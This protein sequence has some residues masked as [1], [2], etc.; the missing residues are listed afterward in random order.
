MAK[1]AAAPLSLVLVGTIAAVF[2]LSL[3]QNN[4]AF[5]HDSTPNI[6]EN[7]LVVTAA[8]SSVTRSGTVTITAT[9]FA[10]RTG[11]GTDTDWSLQLTV[12]AGYTISSGANPQAKSTS[13]HSSAV[14]NW[15][16]TAPA[17]PSGPDTFTVTA[18]A[19]DAS[20]GTP[21]S[22]SP[23]AD[24]FTITTINRNPAAADDGVTIAEDAPSAIF[25][26]LNDTDADNDALFISSVSSQPANGTAIITDTN[27]TVTYSPDPN[28]FG[29]D[30]IGYT[31]H[32]GF[33]GTATGTVTV[34]LTAINDDPV[35]NDD[36]VL[37]A[38]DNATFVVVL[39][40]DTDIDSNS[41]E[42]SV[43]SVTSP[44]SGMAIING[45]NVTLTYTPN[46][47]FN[48]ID[49]F[50]YTISDGSGGAA[51][52][53]VT[54][55]VTSLNDAPVA[56][57]SSMTV[58]EDNQ[59]A[60]ALESN[61]VEGDILTFII[62]ATPLHGALTEFNPSSGVVTYVSEANF[63]GQD[64]FEFIVTDNSANS[65]SAMV[66][67]TVNPVAEAV[68]AQPDR[69]DRDD[70]GR[71]YGG[72][73]DSD[74]KVYD[75]ASFVNDPLSRIQVRSFYLQDSEGNA[76]RESKLGEAVDIH[77]TIR[78]YQNLDQ[79]YVFVV[80]ISDSDNVAVAILYTLGTVEDAGAAKVSLLWTPHL[81]GSYVVKM[82]ILDG[83][84]NPTSLTDFGISAFSVI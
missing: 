68:D 28:F 13:S 48:G 22:G 16:V 62:V 39:A 72:R 29:I 5:A 69:S 57:N 81:T 63:N 14:A 66:S 33:G 35:T 73:R 75:E 53:T 51:S 54:V 59:V 21:L 4:E 23:E 43:V 26:L 71:E 49:V 65:T 6:Q 70:N 64:S 78:N 83:F 47:N 45:D 11:P 7:S 8:P 31:I 37:T 76:I 74:R 24:T 58:D 77:A 34:V 19:T 55:N 44:S 40:N 61:D 52:G 18:S 67:I 25:V 60:I 17:T 9:V 41:S 46:Q 20:L 10:H 36:G 15:N 32:D 80:Q 38:E 12:P 1:R 2:F 84:S 27:T 79:P 82:M 56:Y 3:F 42:L 50:S 30:T